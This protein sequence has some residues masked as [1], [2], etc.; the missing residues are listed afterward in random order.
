MEL[1]WKLLT[2]VSVSVEIK[3]Y[4]GEGIKPTNAGRERWGSNR[5]NILAVMSHLITPSFF[6]DWGH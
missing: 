4:D 2:L 3:I 6:L 5:C 1:V